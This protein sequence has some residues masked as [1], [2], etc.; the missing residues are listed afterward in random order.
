[1]VYLFF[2]LF[3]LET[4]LRRKMLINAKRIFLNCFHDHA[5]ENNDDEITAKF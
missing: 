4:T 2:F 1:M 5:T 3:F